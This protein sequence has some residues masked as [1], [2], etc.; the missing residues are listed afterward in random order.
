VNESALNELISNG[1]KPIIV[2]ID[3]EGSEL[4][5]LNALAK[6]SFFNRIEYFVIEFDLKYE[7]TEELTRFLRKNGFVESSRSGSDNHWDALWTKN[8][9]R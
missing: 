3:V 2:K 4:Q 6:A 8:L 7:T 9:S 5:V 1:E